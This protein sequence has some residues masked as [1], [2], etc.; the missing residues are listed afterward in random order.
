MLLENKAKKGFQGTTY[1]HQLQWKSQTREAQAI[2]A[3][4][5]EGENQVPDATETML[6]MLRANE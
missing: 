2:H 4:N 1:I 3:K 5:S 6:W